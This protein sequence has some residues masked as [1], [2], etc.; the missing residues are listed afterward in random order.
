MNLVYLAMANIRKSKSATGSLIAFILIAS[1]L[2]SIGLMVISQIGTFFDYKNEQLHDPHVT[3]VMEKEAD[4]T[5]HRDYLIDYPGVTELEVEN[6]LK[7]DSAKFKFGGGE[8]TSNVVL[9][10]ADASRNIAPLKVIER[11]DTSFNNDLFV[12]YSLKT[13]G[14]YKLGDPLTITYQDQD[15]TYRVAGFFETTMMGT[16]NIGVMKFML[17]HISYETLVNQL[18]EEARAVI[19]SA[20]M[21][22]TLQSPV[23][24]EDFIEL[25]QKSDDATP[26]IGLD[27]DLVKNVSTL[28][29]N[30]IA[31][32]LVAF[33]AVMVLISLIVIRYRV[34]NSIEDGIANI[35]IL[36]A[37]GYTSRQILSSILLQFMCI[38]VFA[39]TVGIILSY[40]LMPVFGTTISRLTGLVWIQR[41][42]PWINFITM[43]ILVSCVGGVVLISAIR[44][45][46][47]LPVAAL[48]GGIP[49][50]S[51]RR[52]YFPLDWTKGGVHVLLAMKSMLLGAKQNVMILFIVASLTFASIF[53]SVLYYNV[54][55]DKTAFINLFGSE[56]ANLFVTIKPD[57][58]PPNLLHAIEQMD[59]VRKVNILD[60]IE[61]KIDDQ[62]VYTNITEQYS[63]LE[64][65]SV[66]EGREPRH[67][68]EISISWVIAERINKEIGD[69]V[70][71]TYRNETKRYL[72]TGISQAISNLGKVSGLTM[73]GI[74]QLDPEYQGNSLYVYLDGT[75]NKEFIQE[76]QSEYGDAIVETLDID[77]NIE[78]QTGMYTNALFT[79]MILIL[80]ITVL[81]VV[82]ILYLVIKTM[83]LKRK[84]EFG[85]MKAIGYSTTQLMGQIAISFLPVMLVGVTLGGLF[86]YFFTNPMLAVL[87]SAAGVKRLDFI[88]PFPV[89][90]LPCLGMLILGFLVS[91]LV[92]RRIKHISVYA[93]ITE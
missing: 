82:L 53:A 29:I 91:M 57:T 24:Y 28:T 15:Y 86:G 85:V 49:T 83:I 18:G 7:L 59:H 68:N 56:P 43:L 58:D 72:V 41:A 51:F 21:E 14:G 67:D 31:T 87:L 70:E 9:L 4:T 60:L 19:Y 55:S 38:V 23:L 25:V 13:T 79:V 10:N 33:A 34:Y 65:T 62:A 40:G 81:V 61:T 69:M 71:V 39:S 16:N 90:L 63:E 42:D 93:L 11:M 22:E 74:R 17:P 6:I 27:I 50:H 48:R 92:S 3:F 88:V 47:I 76:V 37:I 78:S 64:N 35:G 30:F 66:Y 73:A 45:R 2:L 20:T 52:N 26:V 46:K 75:S 32:L 80:A 36:K 84:R 44:V 5:A 12:P 77:E 54:A 1:L 89:L 8:F